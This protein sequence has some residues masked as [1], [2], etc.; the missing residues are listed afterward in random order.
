M[1]ENRI[2]YLEWLVAKKG[3]IDV[4]ELTADDYRQTGGARFLRA[5]G[6]D[7]LADSA[8]PESS[9]SIDPWDL[10]VLFLF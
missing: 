5:Y 9:K 8:A 7:K 4:S 10:K 1:K 3:V 6:I 2:K